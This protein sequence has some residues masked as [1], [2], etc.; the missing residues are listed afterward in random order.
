[1][2]KRPTQGNDAES[3]H[4]PESRFQAHDTVI[5]SGPK[6][7]TAGLT[8]KCG[9]AHHRRNCGGR[10]TARTA[11]RMVGVPGIAGWGRIPIGK[12][13]GDCLA[14]HNPACLLKTGHCRRIVI[15]NK[16]RINLGTSGGRY[17]GGVENILNPGRDTDQRRT[18]SCI[19]FGLFLTSLLY[20]AFRIN[21]DPR[22][23][24]IE[25]TDAR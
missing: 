19:K 16:I 2:I 11:R 3:T 25:C 12:L 15:G 20:H 17:T 4:P 24:I 7:G 21:T 8:A 9:R 10:A 14:E 1:M 5:G 6:H 22:L 18:G 13:G 23:Q